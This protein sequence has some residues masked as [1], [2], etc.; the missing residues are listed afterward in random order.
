M[1]VLF[2]VEHRAFVRLALMGLIQAIQAAQ[3]VA[4]VQLVMALPMERTQR[5]IAVRARVWHADQEP[6]PLPVCASR[7]PRTSTLQEPATLRAQSAP[8]ALSTLGLLLRTNYCRRAL[9]AT[10]ELMLRF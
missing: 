7:A 4:R 6:S 8:A 2:A 3:F 5:F 10:L 1:L 9:R